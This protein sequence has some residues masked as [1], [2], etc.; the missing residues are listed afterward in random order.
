VWQKTVDP[1]APAFSPMTLSPGQRGTM[2]LT[3]TP[4]GKKGRVVNGTL[5]VD[6]LYNGP[7]TAIG[8]EV[9]AIPYQ[10]TIG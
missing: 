8:G 10:Y 6:V 7:L 2:T 1:N 4:S 5:F 3:I 9:V